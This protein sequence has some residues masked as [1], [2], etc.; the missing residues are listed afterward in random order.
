MA[1]VVAIVLLAEACGI[2][3]FNWFLGVVADHQQ[4]SLAG[5]DPGVM[6]TSSKIGGVIFGLYFALCAL[7]ALLVAIRDR[8]PAGFGRVVLISAAVVHALLGALTWGLVGWPA[9]VFMVVVFT[10]ILLILMSYDR[11]D[12]P[13][14]R[15][16]GG[17]P[18]T[19]GAPKAETGPVETPAG[20]PWAPAP[21]GRTGEPRTGTGGD[22]EPQDTVSSQL[23]QPVPTTL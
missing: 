8:A 7:V 23:T 13:G 18:G 5:V 10:L 15:A 19:G 6:S 16:A 4:M 17:A 3:A 21:G 22:G 9:F 11:Q 12:G 14:Q 2:A 20:A 1:W